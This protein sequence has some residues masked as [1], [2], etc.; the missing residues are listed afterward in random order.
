MT[1][2][3]K[4]IPFKDPTKKRFKYPIPKELGLENTF[5]MVLVGSSGSGKSTVIRNLIRIINLQNIKKPNR[6]IISSTFEDDTTLHSRFHKDNVFTEYDDTTLLELID[7]IMGEN[8]ERRRKK[9][10]EE[11]YLL[12]ADD[13][14]GLIPRNASL[15]SLFVKNRHKKLNVMLSVQ[16]FKALP[17]VV[18]YNATT[19]IIFGTINMKELEN[20]DVELNKKYPNKLFKEMFKE[21]IH[22]HNFLYINVPKQLYLVNFT[23]PLITEEELKKFKKEKGE[24]IND[25][26]E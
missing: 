8:H 17:P 15:W 19:Y 22:G 13:M 14:L 11:Q 26:E 1:E 5:S 24:V 16:Q 20:I 18:R 7:M 25:T 2:E 21:K 9:K 6:F 12:V 3:L 4:I 23:E 10:R